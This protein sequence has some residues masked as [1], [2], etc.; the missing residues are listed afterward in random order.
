M[1]SLKTVA[2]AL[3][4]A[5]VLLTAAALAHTR[6]PSAHTWPVSEPRGRF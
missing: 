1:P 3:L 5:G 6:M 4:A 2:A